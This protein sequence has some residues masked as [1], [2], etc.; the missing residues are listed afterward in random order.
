VLIGI[1]PTRAF[2]KHFF[3]KNKYNTT[4][5][6]F[7]KNQHMQVYYKAFSRATFFAG[8]ISIVSLMY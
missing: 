2:L 1:T 4:H 7:C 8:T 3:R 6:P 5:A